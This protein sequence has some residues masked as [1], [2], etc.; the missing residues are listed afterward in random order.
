MKLPQ[1]IGPNTGIGLL[2]AVVTLVLDQASKLWLLYGFQLEFRGQVSVLPF[3]DF[4]LV[5]NG[6]ISYGLFQQDGAAGRAILI[7]IAVGACGFFLLWLAREHSRLN[8]IALGLMIGGALGNLIDR[9]AYGAVVDFV[10]VHFNSFRW[11]VFNVADVA[12]VVGV[13]LLIYG[14]LGWGSRQTSEDAAGHNGMREG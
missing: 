8:A 12:I 5:W 13:A 14:A 9:V 1:L 2:L 6:G 4:V 7:L 10:L 3:V 11:Y